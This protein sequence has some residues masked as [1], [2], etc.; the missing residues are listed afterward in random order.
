MRSSGHDDLESGHL[1][2][3]SPGP[4]RVMSSRGYGITDRR[5]DDDRDIGLAAE[6]VATLGRLVGDL[7]HRGIEEVRRPSLNHRSHA[8]QGG[9]NGSTEKPGLADR[10]VTNPLRTKFRETVVTA[11]S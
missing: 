5:A 8:G 4:I 11:E 6:H 3:E 10:R 2:E 7:I 9:T 1:R